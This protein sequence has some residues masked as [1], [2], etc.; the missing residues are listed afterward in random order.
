[1]RKPD[2]IEAKLDQLSRLRATGNSSEI[3]PFLSDRVNVVSAK[4][5]TI[6]GELRLVELIPNLVK[7]FDRIMADPAV[8]DKGCAALTAIVEALYDMEHADADVYRR[9]I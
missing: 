3:A 2:R 5:A 1:M 6:A 4:A 7:A 8:L 9:G